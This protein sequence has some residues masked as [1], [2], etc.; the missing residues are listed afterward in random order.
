MSAGCLTRDLVAGLE[1]SAPDV[2]LRLLEPGETAAVL[3]VFAG[4]GPRSR[5]LRFLTAKPQLTSADLRQLTAVDHHDHVAI[6]ATSLSDRRLIGIARFVRQEGR[7]DSADVALAV[8][9][10]WQSRGIGTR[11]ARA[12]VERARDVGVRRFTMTMAVG[13]EAA[14]RL[15]RRTSRQ[16]EP[17]G[18]DAGV[19]EF[20][21][22]LGA[23]DG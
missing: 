18:V 5:E 2:E 23:A 21:V 10:D 19:A 22:D 6:L 14:L 11:L 17:L 8:V 9:D 20:A 3:E 16:V 12:L 7:P 13:N 4:L 1:T 15:L